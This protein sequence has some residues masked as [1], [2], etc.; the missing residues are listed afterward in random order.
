M[1]WSQSPGM[2]EGIACLEI[3]W[4]PRCNWCVA[5]GIALGMNQFAMGSGAAPARWILWTI[6]VDMFW[7]AVC[8]RFPKVAEQEV[9]SEFVDTAFETEKHSAWDSLWS[10]EGSCAEENSRSIWEWRQRME[11][12]YTWSTPGAFRLPVCP[13][14]LHRPKIFTRPTT[15]QVVVKRTTQTFTHGKYVLLEWSVRTFLAPLSHTYQSFL[16]K[17]ALA[18]TRTKI[19]NFKQSS[20]EETSSNGSRQL[21]ARIPTASNNFCRNCRTKNS[22]MQNDSNIALQDLVWHIHKKYHNLSFQHEKLHSGSNWFYFRK[23]KDFCGKCRSQPLKVRSQI[24]EFLIGGPLISDKSFFLIC[25][26]CF[27]QAFSRDELWDKLREE[28]IGT[29]PLFPTWNCSFPWILTMQQTQT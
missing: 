13:R 7:N 2:V 9:F 8:F 14:N 6:L 3:N 27:C 16:W 17:S 12:I 4:D 21:I 28:E 1:F 29:N 25:E 22:C 10:G 18:S 20:C 11:M 24:W 23:I 15:L 19:E 5:S 26:I